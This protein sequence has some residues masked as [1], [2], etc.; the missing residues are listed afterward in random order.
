MEIRLNGKEDR[1]EYKTFS[2]W[3]TKPGN[4]E[5]LIMNLGELKISVFPFD[6]NQLRELGEKLITLSGI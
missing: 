6:R 2:A 4:K 1:I 5:V 3:I